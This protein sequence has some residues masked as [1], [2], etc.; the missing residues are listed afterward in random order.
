M[1]DVA[2]SFMT[3]NH[4]KLA[5]ASNLPAF[6]CNSGLPSE[7]R[8]VAAAGPAPKPAKRAATALGQIFQPERRH[9]NIGRPG[10]ATTG[11]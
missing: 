11:R 6:G 5:A 2:A 8:P 4:T 7:D 10:A 9:V 3:D 1:Q